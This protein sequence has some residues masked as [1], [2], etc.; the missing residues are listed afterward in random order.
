MP[1]SHKR[2]EEIKAIPDEDIDTK[3]IPELD[4]AYWKEAKLVIPNLKGISFLPVETD[5]L[6][7]F[8]AQGENSTARIN[9]VLRDYV[10]AHQNARDERSS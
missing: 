5:I 3:D 10:S 7:W 2:L 1:V 8:E 4:D 9:A 6:E